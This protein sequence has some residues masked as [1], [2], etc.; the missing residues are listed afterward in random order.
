[1]VRYLEAHGVP[2]E[3]LTSDGFG[4]DRPV[5]E[6]RTQEGR[7]KNRRVEFRLAGPQVPTTKRDGQESSR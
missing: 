3:R 5:A 1:V 6:N 4:P 7:A 2:P